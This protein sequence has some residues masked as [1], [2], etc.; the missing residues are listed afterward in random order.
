MGPVDTGQR[1]YWSEPVLTLCRELSTDLSGLA[2]KEAATRLK[3]W[4]TNRI[5]DASHTT[6]IESFAR[7]FR[8]P[9][10]LVLIFAASISVFV[11]NGNEAAIIGLIVLA[12]C[13]LSFSQE[14][15]ASKATEDLRRKISARVTCVRSGLEV[16]VPAEDIVPGDV[17]KLSAGNLIPADGVIMEAQDLNVSE[18]VLTGETFPVL[19]SPGTCTADTP[20]ALRSNVVFAGTSVRSGTATILIAATGNRTEFAK[21]AKALE[22]R[23]PETDFARGTRRFGA[24]MTEIMLVIVIIVLVANL[25][26]HRPLID[27]LLFSLAL[28]VGLTP[29]LLPAI[30]SVTLSRGARSMARRGVIVRRLEAIENLGSMDLLCTDKTGTLTE[31]VIRLDGCIDTDGKPSSDVRLWAT[32]NATLQTGLKN[33]LDE[34]IAAAAV[35]DARIAEYTKISEIPYDFIRKRLTVVVCAKSDASNDI[36]IC[37]GAVGNVMECC[38]SVR[39]GDEVTQF[40]TQNREKLNAIFEEW[41]AQGYRVLGVAVRSSM[42][43]PKYGRDDEAGMLFAGFL[44]FLDPPKAGVSDALTGLKS[45]GVAIKMITGDNRYVARHLAKTV[46]LKS[47][48]VVTGE[49]IDQMTKNALF[50]KAGKTDLFVEINPNQKERVIEALRAHG[51]VVGYMGDGINDAPA[52]HEADIGISVDTAVDVAREAADMILLKQDLGVLLRG[53]DDGRRTFANT[54][55]YISITTSANFGNMISMAFAS[56][57]LPF[58]PL[59]AKQ[60]LLNNLLSSVPSLAIASD[61]V[62]PEQ[63]ET[64]RRWDIGSVRRFMISFGLVSSAFDFLTF[65]FLLYIMHSTTDTF[66]TAWFVESLITQLAI[67]LVVRTHFP[68]WKSRP[69]LVLSGLTFAIALLAVALPYLPYASSFGFVP[70]PL[71]VMLGLGGITALYLMVS[72]AT[73][74]LFF[75]HQQRRPGARRLHLK[76]RTGR[77]R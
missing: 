15:A 25:L 29:E 39:V 13:L 63:I 10:V 77:D 76:E 33:A 17:V 50:G 11:G 58:L 30:I 52:L 28:A 34:A 69:G 12:S 24:L 43:K 48:H 62:D 7:Q 19:K 32:L 16:T 45:R 14:Y 37:K 22:R 6:A 66:R 8:N 27:S 42:R 4:G 1:R 20:L 65:G 31:G 60:I 70:L 21:I 59:L 26:L 44:L 49:D 23:M 9:L 72:E 64:P 75:A 57:F 67:V 68:F 73:K 47:E 51:H 55:K 53:I 40:D 41:S 2:E 5:S 36:I 56:L 71:P 61:N 38:S 74:Q 54:M 18:A 3:Q 46:G 35:T